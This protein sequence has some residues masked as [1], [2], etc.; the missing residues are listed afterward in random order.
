[1]NKKRLLTITAIMASVMTI[2]SCGKPEG[3]YR[4]EFIN[5]GDGPSVEM[6]LNVEGSR[7]KLAIHRSYKKSFR[8]T[9]IANATSITKE[10]G[11]TVFSFEVPADITS[12]DIQEQQK[13]TFKMVVKGTGTLTVL[14]TDDHF[15]PNEP[16]SFKKIDAKDT[17][18]NGAFAR[19]MPKVCIDP[20]CW[21]IY[22]PAMTATDDGRTYV[23]DGNGRISKTPLGT[24]EMLMNTDGMG[25]TIKYGNSGYTK[26]FLY[27]Y[28]SKNNLIHS[29]EYVNGKYTVADYFFNARNQLTSIS[30]EGARLTFTYDD[31]GNLKTLTRTS[32]KNMTMSTY[33]ITA[34]DEYGNPTMATAINGSHSY[35]VIRAYAYYQE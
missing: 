13:K 34:T 23:F 1:M 21:M 31:N 7:A 32:G 19:R 35:Q 26:G 33:T 14:S 9:D 17:A 27:R 18:E 29:E 15:I 3:L 8:Y 11:N 12:T 28:D 20:G 6:Y 10:G 16:M 4:C 2:S 25:N 5:Q 30:R 24:E 22:G